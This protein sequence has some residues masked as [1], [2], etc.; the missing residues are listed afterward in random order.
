MTLATAITALGIDDPH[1]QAFENMIWEHICADAPGEWLQQRTQD[2]TKLAWHVE[3]FGKRKYLTHDPLLEDLVYTFLQKYARFLWPGSRKHRQHLMPSFQFNWIKHLK[4][5]VEYRRDVQ[6][7]EDRDPSLK[8]AAVK[9]RLGRPLVL[10]VKAMLETGK[11]R[12]LLSGKGAGIWLERIIGAE[13]FQAYR[14]IQLRQQQSEDVEMGGIS[15]AA[16]GDADIGA[17]VA[18]MP[19]SHKTGEKRGRD[20]APAV[21]P[22]DKKPRFDHSAGTDMKEPQVT[23]LDQTMTTRSQHDVLT[24]ALPGMPSGPYLVRPVQAPFD[25]HAVH[26][27]E[28]LQSPSSVPTSGGPLATAPFS[29]VLTGL[30]TSE[31]KVARATEEDSNRRVV[32]NG[33]DDNDYFY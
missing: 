6:A 25:A 11:D 31:P 9:S 24:G 32:Y 17:H 29:A 26:L 18:P 12:E 10:Y 14:E 7:W 21:Q 4:V 5:P 20:T 16:A 1:H 22:P 2:P 33:G 15:A 23:S 13:Q 8:E 27:Q 30:A 28:T 3:R 19:A